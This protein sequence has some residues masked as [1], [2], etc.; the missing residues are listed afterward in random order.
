MKRSTKAWLITAL[1][2]TMAGF[3]VFGGI[4]AMIKFDFTKLSTIKYETNIY[5]ISEEFESISVIT[6][7]ANV[8]FVISEESK[9]TV[10]CYEQTKLNHSVSVTDGKLA[11]EAV[12]SRHWYDNISINFDEPQITVYLPKG[13][14]NTLEVKSST[15]SVEIAKDFSF[16]R[17]DVS[18]GTGN[19]AN[20]ASASG[21]IKL[22]ASTGNISVGSVTAASLSLSVSTGNV[23]A[24][25]V[26]KAVGFNHIYLER[27][28]KKHT[29]ESLKHA[30]TT[31]NLELAQNMLLTTDLSI[32]EI[33][34]TLGYANSNGLIILF[35][36]RLGITPLEFK[37]QNQR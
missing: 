6:N 19:V 29:G 9:C 13:E 22:R 12:D 28:F 34:E 5:E 11:I 10:E 4:M 8:S 25:D 32:A 7:T 2:M 36:K 21:D 14:Y 1:S 37:K 26:A 35:K 31:R 23:T 24:S 30:I 17:I 33:A 20:H 3:V 27:I 18:A 16:E 15:G